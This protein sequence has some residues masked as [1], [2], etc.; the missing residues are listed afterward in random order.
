MSIETV[1]VKDIEKAVEDAKG[2]K[3]YLF[4]TSDSPRG[5]QWCKD[6]RDCIKPVEAKLKSIPNSKSFKIYVSHP[7]LHPDEA[8]EQQ[9]VLKKLLKGKLIEVVPTLYDI[10]AEQVVNL[11]NPELEN[12]PLFSPEELV[13]ENYEQ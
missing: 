5:R 13:F 11:L 3:R 10:D 7:G 2:S 9:A 6:C 4:V 8:L 12:N 1:T